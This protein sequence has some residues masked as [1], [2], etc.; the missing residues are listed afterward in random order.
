MLHFHGPKP[1][2][3][4]ALRQRIAD[5]VQ[6]KLANGY[7]WKVCDEWDRLLISAGIA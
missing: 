4:P 1:F 5:P 3:R 6:A 7:F 2:L